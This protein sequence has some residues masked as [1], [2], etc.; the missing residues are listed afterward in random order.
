[1][2]GK[3]RFHNVGKVDSG[4]VHDHEI[5]PWV[6]RGNRRHSIP[7][8]KPGC[9]EKIVFLLNGKH[10]VRDIHIHGLCGQHVVQATPIGCMVPSFTIKI[11]H[12][13]P[14]GGI[15][16]PVVNPR[17]IGHKQG[18]DFTFGKLPDG[19]VATFPLTSPKNENGCR[20]K[21]K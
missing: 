19:H 6:S 5:L 16:R 17:G 10:K 20:N 1:M 3:N 4:N 21:G 2:F 8:G 9:D 14:G 7:P 13:T 15:E 11:E 12:T 18:R